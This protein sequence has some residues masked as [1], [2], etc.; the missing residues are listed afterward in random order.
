VAGAPT[1]TPDAHA[2]GASFQPLAALRLIIA[3]G[4]DRRAA[5]IALDAVYREGRDVADPGVIAELARELGV[6]GPRAALE[7]RPSTTPARQHQLGK[8][9][10]G[11]FGVPTLVIGD[12]LFWGT[13][14]STWRLSTCNIGR[15]S[16]SGHAG[17]GHCAGRGD[18]HPVSAHTASGP[19]PQTKNVNPESTMQP[20]AARVPFLLKRFAWLLSCLSLW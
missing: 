10:R 12:E 3:A 2:T 19:C 7:T 6:G 14:H 5:G 17:R 1:G 11:I 13:T 4:S 16:G 20:C 8:A 9:S 15:L 18:A